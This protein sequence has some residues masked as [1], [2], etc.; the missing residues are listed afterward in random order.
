MGAGLDVYARNTMEGGERIHFQSV[1][2]HRQAWYVDIYMGL[3]RMWTGLTKRL[4]ED[5]W[6]WRDILGFGA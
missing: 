5:Q 4:D 1:P 2:F 3:E 6:A